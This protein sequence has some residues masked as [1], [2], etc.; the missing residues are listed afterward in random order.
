MLN[1]NGYKHPAS[2][3]KKLVYAE[4]IMGK[5]FSK[6]QPVREATLQAQ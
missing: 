4:M 1:L 3:E 5:E 2:C 6:K